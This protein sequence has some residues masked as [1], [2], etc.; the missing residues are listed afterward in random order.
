MKKNGFGTGIIV[1][2]LMIFLIFVMPI[3]I[4]YSYSVGKIAPLIITEVSADGTIT[5]YGA[6]L[7]AIATACLGAF[8]LWQN[9]IFKDENDKVQKKLSDLTFS[10]EKSKMLDKYLEYV[11]EI[12]ILIDMNK[13]KV[14]IH[15][16]RVTSS[17]K[18]M[19]VIRQKQK[20]EDIKLRLALLDES[21]SKHEYYNFS[22]EIV[23]KIVDDFHDTHVH[24]ISEE[25]VEENTSKA[26]SFI[27][28]I[29]N[30]LDERF[31]I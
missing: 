14:L 22:C 30:S 13:N 10:Q 25:L 24:P 26:K 29:S 19:V 17:D 4:G 21:N 31:K 3:F 8:A 15:H 20:I 28:D 27:K 7:S 1:T 23:T 2:L 18:T 6:V 16:E 12:N 5:F 9:K 11:A